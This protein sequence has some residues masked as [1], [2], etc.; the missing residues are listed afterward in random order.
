[1]RQNQRDVGHGQGRGKQRAVKFLSGCVIAGAIAAP[2]WTQ[3]QL[4]APD[5]G[6]LDWFGFHVDAESDSAIVGS[7]RDRDAGSNTGS[8][9]I[10]RLGEEGA[11]TYVQKLVLDSAA[12]GDLAGMHVAVDGTLATVSAPG[13]ILVREDGSSIKGTV[14]VFQ[15][16]D[17]IWEQIAELDHE[18]RSEGDLFGQS[19]SIQRGHVLIGAPRDDEFA[20]DGGAVYVFRRRRGEWTFSQKLSP[21]DVGTHD[22]FG[23]AVDGTGGRAMASSY[24][25]D[26]NGVNAGAVYAL[27]RRRGV[28]SIEQKL[29]ASEG[30]NFDFFGTCVALSGNR[31][32]IG[33][34]QSEDSDPSAKVNEG[35]AFVFQWSRSED[36]WVETYVLRPGDPADEQRFGIDVDI[37]GS[38]I[39]V[40]ASH[41]DFGLSN[42]GSAHIFKQRRRDWFEVTRYSS[43]GKQAYDYLG[44][45]VAIGDSIVIGAP[46]TNSA[47]SYEAG[48]GAV[49]VLGIPEKSAIWGATFCHSD[50]V[51][52]GFSRMG[53]ERNR[54]GT[55]GRLTSAGGASV[56]RD[57]LVLRAT[58]L[59]DDSYGVLAMGTRVRR[60]PLGRGTFCIREDRPNWRFVAMGTDSQMR[61]IQRDMID[62]VETMMEGASASIV[63]QR[64]FAQ[65]AYY[66]R[67]LGEWNTTNAIRINF[68][69]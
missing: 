46:G 22:F 64:L 57:N 60:T 3:T 7:W 62:R 12:G 42:S 54:L 34:P 65:V 2:A 63:G 1:M 67:V 59:T 36:M 20:P 13:R 11:A 49:N 25:D 52:L 37:Q 23:H 43:E 30:G 61:L 18:S 33:A 51:E 6:A 56:S 19:V 48:V 50:E 16:V 14:A 17:G 26:D 47:T 15:E 69:Q 28:W 8:A 10:L 55:L 68:D 58:G 5:A 53:G 45:S 38:T 9:H 39:V 44:L 24:N 35:A 66:D 32:V 27:R 21:A 4:S 29:V 40:G 41:S 31:A